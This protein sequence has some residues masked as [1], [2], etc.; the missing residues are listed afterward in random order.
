MV[1]SIQQ[2]PTLGHF[3]K[4]ICDCL[5]LWSSD[6]KDILFEVPP[7]EAKRRKALLE[8]FAT[9]EKEGGSYGSL[10]EVLSET[11]E[12]HSDHTKIIKKNKTIQDYSN[13]LSKEDFASVHEFDEFKQ[14]VNIV[15]CDK[16]KQDDLSGFVS[17][18]YESSMMYYIEFIREH[19]AQP[20]AQLASYVFFVKNILTN[21]IESL[22]GGSSMGEIADDKWPLKGFVDSVAEMCNVSLYKLHQFHQFKLNN[23][24][25]TDEEIWNKDLSAEDQNSRSKQV[26][27]SLKKKSK[28][29]WDNIYE[30][31]EPLIVLLPEDID[32]KT[33][34]IKAYAAFLKQNIVNHISNIDLP[35]KISVPSSEN[36]N[37][38]DVQAENSYLP[39]SDRLDLIFNGVELSSDMEINELVVL[40]QDFTTKVRLIN[41]SLLRDFDFP[42]TMIFSYSERLI[43]IPIEV[44]LDK[45]NEIP[46]WLGEMILARKA[47]KSGKAILALDHY[48]KSLEASK[49]IAGPL[50]MVLYVDICAFCKRQYRELKER[51]ETELFDRFYDPLGSQVTSYAELLGYTPSITRDPKT[52]SPVSNAGRKAHIMIKKIDSLVV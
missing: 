21:L 20:E 27:G 50:F 18:I 34:I 6:K 51:N 22:V 1:S 17:K 47:V 40:L 8:A 24:S 19:A 31:I 37:Y 52:L 2:T 4:I 10:T 25:C 7:T 26:V 33:F 35:E 38:P 15:I 11:K 12:N 45:L 3:N 28:K 9:I 36:W 5:G 44:L 39:V 13:H 32:K 49:Y 48:K 41:S 29:K 30:V 42:N 43:N 46:L 16:F 14:H 23:R